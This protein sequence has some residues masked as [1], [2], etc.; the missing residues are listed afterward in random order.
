LVALGADSVDS[1]GGN[2]VDPHPMAQEGGAPSG[3]AVDGMLEEDDP[4][5][6]ETHPLG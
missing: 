6:W 5:T 2:S 4:G 1:A 3:V